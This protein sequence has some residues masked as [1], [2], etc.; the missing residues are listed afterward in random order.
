MQIQK[1]P[2]QR[3]VCAVCYLLLLSLLFGCFLPRPAEPTPVLAP[4]SVSSETPTAARGIDNPAAIAVLT[5]VVGE[6]LVDEPITYRRSVGLMRP[7]PAEIQATAFQEL[8]EGSTLRAAANAMA[9]IVC[10]G[11]QAYQVA[12][13]TETVVNST[14]C[15]SGVPLPPGSV[16]YVAPTRGRL[17]DNDGSA[18]I[19]GETR[20]READYGQ[21]PIIVSPRNS[22]LFAQA[23]TISWV[24]V[25]SALEYVLSLSGLAPFEEVTIAANDVACVADERTAPNR[26]CSTAWPTA[27]QLDPAQR[28]FLTV[29][30]RTGIA[31]PLRESEPSAL[32]TLAVADAEQLQATLAAIEALNLDLL[33]QNLL[34]AGR[35]REAGL[36]A[37]A[38]AAY[39][40]AYGI[41]TTPEVAIA[42]GDL[43][44]AVDLQRFAFLAYQSALDQLT[45]TGRADKAIEAAAGFGIGLVYY[46]RGN[47]AEAELHLRKA[48]ALYAAI[49]ATEEQAHAQI[50][51]EAAQK[52][53][54]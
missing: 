13:G 51:L 21:L 15:G 5:Y 43:Y 34:M 32:R 30:A 11:E 46:S 39:E 38:I 41:Q 42:L 7:V 23:P 10:Y 33:T 37:Q 2:I 22:T 14:T 12:G 36:I 24:E 52:R 1:R 48:I 25:S 20:E 50:A 3:A 27:W 35:F 9:T 53:H 29:A 18:I 54:S 31:A 45:A 44:L 16:P 26:I 17:I 28:Y 4:T 8:R 6:V 19:E 49:G 40:A 47:Y